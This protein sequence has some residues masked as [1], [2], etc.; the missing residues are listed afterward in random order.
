M[1]G[2]LMFRIGVES[3]G[4]AVLPSGK[5][6]CLFPSAILILPVH[7]GAELDKGRGVKNAVF[8]HVYA[9]TSILEQQLYVW[10]SVF[11]H[12]ACFNVSLWILMGA[13]CV[14]REEER[15]YACILY[16]SPGTLNCDNVYV[17]EIP[18]ASTIDEVCRL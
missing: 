10:V 18:G 9:S 7:V 2:D 14:C 15:V 12:F 13:I 16:M 11:V 1:I 8:V 17:I 4:N 5:A 3:Q 6:V